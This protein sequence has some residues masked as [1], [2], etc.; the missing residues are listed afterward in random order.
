MGQVIIINDDKKYAQFIKSGISSVAQKEVIIS[1]SATDAIEQIKNIE[2]IDL[3]ISKYSIKKEPSFKIL[4]RYLLKESRIVNLFILEHADIELPSYAYQISDFKD[5]KKVINA[6]LREMG[7][8]LYDE[9]KNSKDG[10]KKIN[11]KFLNH[12]KIAPCDIFIRILKAKTKD[13]YIKRVH[14][15]DIIDRQ[16]IDRYSS[17]NIQYL[18]VGSKNHQLLIR[19]IYAQFSMILSR[20]TISLER[21]V[22]VTEDSYSF[23]LEQISEHNFNLATVNLTNSIINSLKKSIIQV[24]NK[25]KTIELIKLLI[26][27]T[28]SF[29]YK[30]THM[31]SLFS[32][33]II[34]NSKWGN[35]EQILK[36]IQ[37][38]FFH[39]LTLTE[40]KYA[41]IESEE[42][43]NLSN[44]HNDEKQLILN[45]A[46]ESSKLAGKF[47][48]LSTGVSLIIKQHHGKQNG[49]GFSDSLNVNMISKL[50]LVFIIAEKFTCNFLK[51]LESGNKVKFPILIQELRS[52][53][54]TRTIQVI[55]DS[56][57]KSFK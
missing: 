43:L 47:P 40:D 53:Y 11:V 55:I 35:R 52:E 20:N 21:R 16:L 23:C 18:F 26:N 6:C 34:N 45:H 49:I 24:S 3:I 54:P 56:L 17:N 37:V 2:Q 5:P 4:N 29:R 32:A 33:S 30:H 36:L 10:F 28:D 57:M 15:G 19:C 50:A 44:F 22:K 14:K 27:D 25:K 46:H 31:I 39:D 48:N 38:A 51:K 42:E 9:S 13:Q 41:L 1:A 8:K 7:L 12:I